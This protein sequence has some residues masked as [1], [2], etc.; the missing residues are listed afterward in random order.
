MAFHAKGKKNRR[1]EA[2]E[3]N[4]LAFIQQVDYNLQ[5]SIFKSSILTDS[6]M[7]SLS[8]YRE[9]LKWCEIIPLIIC[10]SIQAQALL[11]MY[12]ENFRGGREIQSEKQN[13]RANSIQRMLY[14]CYQV[15]HVVVCL[16]KNCFKIMQCEEGRSLAL[17]AKNV[18]SPI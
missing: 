7:F 3:P 4:I 13:Q 2:E 15:L 18:K 14:L 5:F 6:E 9:C 16:S 12:K 10:L 1:D 17:L 11:Y 8:L